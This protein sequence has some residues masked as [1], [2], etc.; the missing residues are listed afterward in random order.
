MQASSRIGLVRIV[1]FVQLDLTHHLDYHL[2]P[3]VS[4]GSTVIR[5][6]N[7]LVLNVE[8][9]LTIPMLVRTHHLLVLIVHREPIFHIQVPQT[10]RIALIVH[11][12][13]MEQVQ[14]RLMMTTVLCVFQANSHHHQ[15]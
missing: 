8:L 4:L 10:C 15:S 12:V 6:V 14:A 7:H 3:H 5:L 13:D 11:L 9:E 1:M 2:A